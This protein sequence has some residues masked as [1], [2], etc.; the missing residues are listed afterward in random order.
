[1]SFSKTCGLLTQ[2][3][4]DGEF[5]ISTIFENFDKDDGLSIDDPFA[6]FYVIPNDITPDTLGSNGLNLFTGI[7]QINLNYPTSTGE[8]LLLEKAD[9]ISEFF[10]IG[11]VFTSDGFS[12]RIKRVVLSSGQRDDTHWRRIISISWKTR[13]KR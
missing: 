2:V 10:K 9:A 8:S 4:K 13:F 1:M 3:Y 6:E 5:G 11:R 12:L 7:L